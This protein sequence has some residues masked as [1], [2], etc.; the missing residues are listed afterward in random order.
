MGVA[1]GDE[2]VRFNAAVLAISQGFG[3]VATAF[4]AIGFLVDLL[5]TSLPLHTVPLVL[6]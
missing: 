1:I 6:S 4:L 3:I 2:L 5:Q